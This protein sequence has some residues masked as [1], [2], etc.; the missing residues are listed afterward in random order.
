MA[1][2][3]GLPTKK[4]ALWVTSVAPILSFQG[5]FSNR[6]GSGLETGRRMHSTTQT[7]SSNN[8][9][10]ILWQLRRGAEET[11]SAVMFPLRK[12]ATLLWWIKSTLEGARY[13]TTTSHALE[14]ADQVRSALEALGWQDQRARPRR[15]AARR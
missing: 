11:A 1:G 4:S 7:A 9:P 2:S 8:R 5:V 13:F 6:P 14:A 10:T 12:D 15:A 3:Y